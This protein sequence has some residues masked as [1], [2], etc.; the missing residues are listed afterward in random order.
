MIFNFNL[1][2]LLVLDWIIPCRCTPRWVGLFDLEQDGVGN[3]A[4][5][6]HNQ[7]VDRRG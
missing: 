4:V 3:L 6:D 7:G 1:F 5:H 2:D